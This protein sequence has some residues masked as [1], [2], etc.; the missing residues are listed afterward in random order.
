MANIYFFWNLKVSYWHVL[1]SMHWK[2]Y[3][4]G[5]FV[6]ERC[7]DGIVI[8]CPNNCNDAQSISLS[9][10]IEVSTADLKKANSQ[11]VKF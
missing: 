8:L 9:Y 6:V 2:P 10:R 7:V 3:S 11:I 5:E 1:L 4:D